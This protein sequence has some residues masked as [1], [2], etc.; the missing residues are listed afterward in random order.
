MRRRRGRGQEGLGDVARAWGRDRG[1][2]AGSQVGPSRTLVSARRIPEAS[3][4]E[5][6]NLPGLEP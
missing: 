3:R 1:E 2:G 4:H 5:Y 6:E